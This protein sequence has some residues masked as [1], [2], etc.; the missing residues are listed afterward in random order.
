MC[1]VPINTQ[2]EDSICLFAGSDAVAVLRSAGNSGMVVGRAVGFF[3]HSPG[4]P[5]GRHLGWPAP[6]SSKSDF[7]LFDLSVD[8]LQILTR[9]SSLQGS[10]RESKKVWHKN[11][12]YYHPDIVFKKV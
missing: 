5:F 7:V 9:D 2:I 12:D 10:F 8:T 4:T 1:L 3:S 11:L 6:T